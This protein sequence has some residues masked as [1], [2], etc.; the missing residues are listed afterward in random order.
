M[1]ALTFVTQDGQFKQAEI[2]DPLC[3]ELRTSGAEIIHIDLGHRPT[4]WG[5]EPREE[6]LFCLV[7]ERPEK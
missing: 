4:P 2:G 5:P 7:S 1:C 3:T 6:G